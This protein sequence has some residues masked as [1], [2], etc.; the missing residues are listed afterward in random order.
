MLIPN[1]WDC[2]TALIMQD[3]GFK[4]L[5][6]TSA[7]LAFSQGIKEDG[8]QLEVKLQH[9]RDVARVTDIPVSADMQ[10]CFADT[11]EGVADVIDQVME[12]GVAGCSIEDASGDP[13]M[14]V[15]EY[16][17][18]VERVQA[19][20]ERVQHNDPDFVLTARS[21]NYL[22]GR[23][24]LNDTLSRLQAFE[25][26]G[27]DVLYAP[28]LPSLMEIES[29][30]NALSKPVNAIVGRANTG[31]RLEELIEAGVKRISVGSLFYRMAMGQLGDLAKTFLDGDLQFSGREIPFS[32]FNRIC[33]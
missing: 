24:D 9:C 30:C 28:G 2:G 14:P 31:F 11:P 13:D 6:T 15:F 5:A 25:K 20:A 8:L 26:C 4:A 32:D 16:S 3:L 18:A 21:E 10:K 1:P 23:K 22:C 7:G 17:L 19:A 33:E 29:V 12:T 27:A